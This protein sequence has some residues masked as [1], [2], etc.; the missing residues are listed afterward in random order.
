M[1]DGRKLLE[2]GATASLDELRHPDQRA[3]IEIAG[4]SGYGSA[5]AWACAYGVSQ[6][7]REPLRA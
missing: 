3:T 5:C 7:A 6:Y 4:G 2:G 1:T